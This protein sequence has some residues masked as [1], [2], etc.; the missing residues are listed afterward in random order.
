MQGFRDPRSPRATR[1]AQ[2]FQGTPVHHP[3]CG[4]V[5][6]LLDRR[7]VKRRKG[8]REPQITTRLCRMTQELQCRN[9]ELQIINRRRTRRRYGARVTRNPRSPRAT[10]AA[11]EFRE[12]QVTTRP[13]ERYLICR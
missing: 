6:S 7:D 9:I 5:C 1:A 2:G 11:Q 10:R 12:P 4:H 8:F 3:A 13:S